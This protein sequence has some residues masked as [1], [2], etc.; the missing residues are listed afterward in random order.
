MKN[1]VYS[2]SLALLLC[3]FLIA[4]AISLPAFAVEIDGN[5]LNYYQV[6]SKQDWELAP[7]ITESEIVMNTAAGNKRQVSHVV[8]IDIHNPN[9]KVIPSTYKMAEGLENRD[10]RTQTMSQ[11]AKYAE[12]HGYGDVVAAMNTTLHWYDTDYYTRHPE[13]I[14]EPLGTLILDGVKYTNS[15]SSYFGAYTC[16]VINFDEKEG[17][18][19]PDSIPKTEIRQTYDAITGWEEQ[20]IPCNFHFLV[21]NGVSEHVINDPTEPAP[22]SFI[23][24]KADGTIILVMNEGRN[25]PYSTGFN[26]YEMAEFM[27]SLGC[28]HAINCDGGGSSTFLSQRPGEELQLHCT[29]S[30]GSERPVTNGVL[31]ISTASD[32]FEKATVSAEGD[33]YTPGSTVQFTAEGYAANGKAVDLPSN[34]L[35][36]LSDTSFGT[37]DNGRFVSNGKEGTVTVQLTVDGKTVGED[38]ISIVKPDAVTFISETMLVPVGNTVKL[39]LKASYQGNNVIFMESEPVFSLSEVI[40]TIEGMYFTAGQGDASSAEAILMATVCGISAAAKI[41]LGGHTYRVSLE[42][43]KIL[44]DCGCNYTETGLQIIDGKTYYTVGGKL[45]KGWVAV[46]DAWYYFDKADFAGADGVYTTADN[47]RFTFDQGRVTKGTWIRNSQGRRYW[48]GPDYYRDNTPDAAS[49]APYEIDGKTYLFNRSGYLQTGV[50]YSYDS[51]LGQR[52]YDCGTDGAASLLT[53]FYQ[54]H[55]YQ[56][57]V[58]QKAYQ[59]VEFEGDYYFIN[60]YHKPFKNGTIDLAARFTS[61]FNLPAGRYT[62]DAAGKMVINHGVVGDYLYLNGVLQKAYQLIEFEGSYY[63]VNDY[64]KLLKNAAIDL[65]TRFTSQYGLP[66]GRYAFDAEGKLIINHGVVGDYL[67][68]NGVLQKAYQLVEF[69]GGY[70]FINDYNKLLKNA[71]ISLSEK[72]TGP[73]GI[74]AGRYSFD[75]NGR[76][77]INHGVV[78]DCLYINGVLQKA[79]QLAEFEGSYYF[80][81]DHNKLLKNAT[82]DLSSRFTAQYGLPAGRYAFDANGRMIIN[83]GV[84]GDYFYIKG[85]LQKAYQLVEFEG[86]YYFINDY[87]KLLKNATISLSEKFT[88]PFGIPAGRYTFD[89]DGKMILNH[90]VVGDYLYINGVLQRAYQLVEF[91]GSYYFVNDY[92][93]L[94]KN[95]RIYLSERFVG[96]VTLPDGSMLQADYY[97]FDANGRLILN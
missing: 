26:C 21:K 72:F 87:N 64:N 13:L 89:A 33:Y 61:K 1:A 88:G 15:Q 2:R 35:W 49:S 52:Y 4:S 51:S 5:K 84:V 9:T 40:G 81:N 11:Q 32:A 50:V 25:E 47:V 86:N 63:F 42:E 6:I 76:M 7:G 80:V 14:G 90:G 92:N 27:I 41:R 43:G 44:C 85:Q 91:E 22:R 73:Y 28:V 48:Y 66:A 53:G 79:Y 45:Q 75:A 57:G 82:V 65:G 94:L 3:F 36:Q 68:L 74:P 37:V 16:L 29:P 38:T 39:D 96:G 70:Y 23:G 93:K 10:Y 54:E 67:Y 55:F 31:V 71:T 78:G 18:S 95:K 34:A 12:E 62:F 19:R 20:V 69:E 17:V 60:D 46:N 8:E 24:I 30:D 59:L 77:I 56:D 97:S 58:M 83:H